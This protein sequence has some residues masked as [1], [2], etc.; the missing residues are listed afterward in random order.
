[1]NRLIFGCG[2]LGQRVAERWVKAGDNVSAFTRSPARAK[3]LQ[4]LGIQPIVGDITQPH[5]LANLPP[6]D[7]ILFAVGMDR[8]KYSDIRQVYVEGM[9]S[10]LTRL[11]TE[12]TADSIRRFMY[13]SSTGVYG[14]FG[15]EWIDETSPTNPSREGGKACVEAE[16]LI[17]SSPFAEYGTILRFAGIYG[18]DRVPTRKL[19]ET[20]DWNKLSPNGY[21]NLIHV[22]DG[23]DIIVQISNSNAETA[24]PIAA[25]QCETFNVSDGAPPLRR[26]Y[27]DFVAEKIGRPRHLWDPS[28][29]APPDSRGSANKRVSNQKLTQRFP[30]EFNYPDFKSGLE[31]AM[32]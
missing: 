19:I 21:L 11:G 27:Y 25:R 5:T 26:D 30:F 24:A 18:P 28:Q 9:N 4:K 31:Q 14:D 32:A 7:T 22:E 20:Q 15:G 2:Y 3:S 23:A 29:P 13:V 12:A 10:V 17:A 6:A 8:S 16:G 1:M